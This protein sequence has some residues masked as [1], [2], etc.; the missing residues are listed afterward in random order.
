MIANWAPVISANKM[1]RLSQGATL[2]ILLL[3]LLPLLVMLLRLL[4]SLLLHVMLPLQSSPNARLLFDLWPDDKRPM[5]ALL[6]VTHKALTLL[7][8]SLSL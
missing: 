1:L 8:L 7:S 5:I 2:L 3:L 6:S 4:Y